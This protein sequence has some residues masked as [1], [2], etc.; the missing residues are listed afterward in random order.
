MPGRA[1]ENSLCRAQLMLPCVPV[2]LFFLYVIPFEIEDYYSPGPET[3]SWPQKLNPDAS[4]KVLTEALRRKMPLH[5]VP[6]QVSRVLA[7]NL[8]RKLKCGLSTAW[9]GACLANAWRLM[10][11]PVCPMS[12]LPT[13]R[14]PSE[15]LEGLKFQFSLWRVHHYCSFRIPVIFSFPKLCRDGEEKRWLVLSHEE[16]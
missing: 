13:P 10:S 4:N 3:L 7:L 16:E 11:L 2:F 14:N 6:V 9:T 15:L 12:F 5:K 8:T 1:T